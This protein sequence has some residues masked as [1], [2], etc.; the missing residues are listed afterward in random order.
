VDP[1]NL[2]G[3][4]GPLGYPAPFWFVELFKVLGFTLHQAMMHLWYAGMPLAA[5][6]TLAPGEHPRRLR[7]RL[8]TAM[9]VV[10][11]L[12]INLG[13][14]PLLFTQVAYYRTF[15]PAGILMAWPWFS[16]IVLLTLAYYGVYLTAVSVR[17]GWRPRLGTAAGWMAA[18][19]FV[20]IGFLFA[21]AFSLMTYVAGWPAI[22]ARTDAAGAVTGMALNTDDPT[23]LPRWLMLFGLALITTAAAIAVDSAFLAGRETSGYQAVAARTAAATAT[24]GLAVFG[25]MGWW[26]IFGRLDRAILEGSRR[27]P[28]VPIFFAL[29]AAL[30]AV[31]WALLVLQRRG[32]S[33]RGAV[34]VALVQVLALGA[35]ALARQWVQNSELARYLDVAAEPVRMQWSP[36]ILFL[37]LFVGG[38]AVVSWLIAQVVAVHRREA[39][40]G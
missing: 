26:Y 35:N 1:Q 24:A 18:A 5:V 4:A 22:A 14:V 2:I 10:V 28:V 31:T 11:A 15:Y 27:A 3:P 29:A 36:L 21:N 23:L 17:W 39:T 40:G 20:V 9:P 7:A 30:P 25:V 33:R 13:I 37:L 32:I 8:L 19:L 16:V 12:G 6:L 34:G 38:L